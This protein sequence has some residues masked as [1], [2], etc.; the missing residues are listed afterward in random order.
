MSKVRQLYLSIYEAITHGL[1]VLMFSE[2]RQKEAPHSSRN[3]EVILHLHKGV[4]DASLF[5]AEAWRKAMM[6]A[7]KLP[8]GHLGYRQ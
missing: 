5:P 6:V 2:C 8:A 3:R 7:A 1:V 4:P